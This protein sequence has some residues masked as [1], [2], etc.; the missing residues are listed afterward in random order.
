MF[1][2]PKKRPVVLK[3]F[4]LPNPP[5]SNFP[6]NTESGL[7]HIKIDNSTN[8]IWF[9]VSTVVRANGYVHSGQTN[10]LYRFSLLDGSIT[11]VDIPE[12]GIHDF[13]PDGMGNVFVITRP[14]RRVL[15][16]D[17]G[18]GEFRDMQLDCVNNISATHNLFAVFKD[19][20]YDSSINMFSHDGDPV[21][22]KTISR[23]FTS[24]QLFLSP[25][26][27]WFLLYSSTTYGIASNHNGDITDCHPIVNENI[28]MRTLRDPELFVKDHVNF[29]FYHS[30]SNATFNP[31]VPERCMLQYQSIS[32]SIEP[33]LME[34]NLGQKPIF[35]R[36]PPYVRKLIPFDD[37]SY[38]CLAEP[39]DNESYEIHIISRDS[40]VRAR[41]PESRY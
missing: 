21:W 33:C 29:V 6:A 3:T 34:Y 14:E 19:D 32:K 24:L 7:G 22:N 20:G 36:Y 40:L 41:S 16:W 10:Y 4:H 28:R 1:R 26:S 12:T 18:S 17:G 13:A 38:L 9:T 5:A 35:Y 27:F 31:S 8:S 37:Q 25:S 15:R 2:T 23:M 39:S 30:L 11:I